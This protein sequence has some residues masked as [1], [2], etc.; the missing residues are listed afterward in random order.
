MNANWE[1][2]LNDSELTLFRKFGYYAKPLQ[3]INGEVIALN[4]Q[5]CNTKNWELFKSKTDPGHQYEWLV[6]KLYELE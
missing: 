3:G 4:S 6:N 1:G 5:A 2:W